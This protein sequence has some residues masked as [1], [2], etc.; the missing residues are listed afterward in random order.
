MCCQPA[1]N[2]ID[3]RSLEIEGGL[4]AG[5]PVL[6]E[7][8]EY[9]ADVLVLVL[10]RSARAADRHLQ[11]AVVFSLVIPASCLILGQH[12]EIIR[13]DGV[14]LLVAPI[15]ASHCRQLRRSVRVVTFAALLLPSLSL[16]RGPLHHRR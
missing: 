5:D 15:V 9:C 13:D 14:I 3:Q 11:P 1:R 12:S 10:D 7:P 4:I 8:L 16:S 2:G 6:S